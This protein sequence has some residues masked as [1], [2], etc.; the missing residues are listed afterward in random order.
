MNFSAST[1]S[2]F[3]IAGL[4]FLRCFP[5]RGYLNVCRSVCKENMQSM[6]KSHEVLTRCRKKSFKGQC[7][8]TLTHLLNPFMCL[9]SRT[10]DAQNIP[11]SEKWYKLSKFTWISVKINTD[12]HTHTHTQTRTHTHTH[13]H[14]DLISK[15]PRR[16]GSLIF[17]LEIFTIYNLSSLCHFSVLPFNTHTHTHI[18]MGRNEKEDEEG[19]GGGESLSIK[20][21][22]G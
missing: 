6:C 16:S 22:C 18:P 4:Y 10:Y 8:A 15:A 11:R 7:Q 12:T 19:E 17:S 5:E 13:T 3:F 21:W 2:N 20:F 1:A 14:T 9:T